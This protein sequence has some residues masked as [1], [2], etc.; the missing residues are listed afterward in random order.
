[1]QIAIGDT[2]MSTQ[3]IRLNSS[4]LQFKGVCNQS[5]LRPFARVHVED[6]FQVTPGGFNDVSCMQSFGYEL[7]DI[8]KSS[9]HAVEILL[10]IELIAN[11]KAAC[12]GLLGTWWIIASPYCR[13]E[14]V[15][16]EGQALT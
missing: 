12:L 16:D 8:Q 5:I 10:G 6:L 7:N 15:S 9:N 13:G 1:M 3:I 4:M 14:P 2:A 11:E